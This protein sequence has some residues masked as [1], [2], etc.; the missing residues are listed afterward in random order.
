MRGIGGHRVDEL[1]EQ[2]RD[3]SEVAALSHEHARE[4]LGRAEQRRPYEDDA[5]DVLV[6]P[7][8]GERCAV[9]GKG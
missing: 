9:R 6:E 2:T 5:L 3:V 7:G 4:D 8:G 1:G